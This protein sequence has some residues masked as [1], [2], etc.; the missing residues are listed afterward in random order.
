MAAKKTKPSRGQEKAKGILRG[1]MPSKRTINLMVV[2]KNKIKPMQAIPAVLAVLV[3]AALFSKYLVM[4]RL[5]EM[6]QANGKVARLRSTLDD[7]MQAL[8]DIG[9]VNNA[10]AHYTYDGMTAQEMGLVNR[11]RVVD[12]V[13]S[14]LPPIP[15][16]PSEEDLPDI[17]NRIE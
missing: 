6:D 10:Y 14:V 11:T 9:D 15:P 2:D 5:T 13:I 8:E 3:L 1:R 17:A 16:G 7:T 4:D 12:L